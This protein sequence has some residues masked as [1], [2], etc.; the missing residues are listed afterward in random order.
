MG[1]TRTWTVEIRIIE[2]ED[3][4]RTPSGVTVRWQ[5]SD[6]EVAELGDDPATV[7]ALADLAYQA[8]DVAAGDF[9]QFSRRSMRMLS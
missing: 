4:G 3:G 8:L 2:H 6:R 1:R 5:P 7:R 9:G